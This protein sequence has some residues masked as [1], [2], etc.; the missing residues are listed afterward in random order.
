MV[1]YLGHRKG[2]GSQRGCSQELFMPC[3]LCLSPILLDQSF[4]KSEEELRTVAY[5]LGEL[6]EFISGDTVKLITTQTLFDFIDEF[7]WTSTNP[8]LMVEIYKFLSQLLLRQD[9]RIVD[10]DKYLSLVSRSSTQTYHSHPLPSRCENQEGLLDLW[11]DELG[12]ILFV[13]DQCITDNFFIGIA[14]ANGFAGQSVDEYINPKGYRAFPLISPSNISILIDAYE[15]DIPNDIHQRNVSVENVKKNCKAIGGV[16]EKPDRDS[17]Y[18]VKFQGQRSWTFSIN[19]DPVPESYL[20][21]LVDLTP[22][23][24]SVIKAALIS[25]N[26]PA[27]VLRLEK[28]L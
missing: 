11:S 22:Y 1:D 16:L 19:D 5:A 28:L 21:E 4:P 14:C 23:P 18:K 2:L 7:D 12:K 13:H 10:V 25:G 24:K 8:N 6:E 17:H 27:K 26:L 20:R 9:D 15:W 3:L